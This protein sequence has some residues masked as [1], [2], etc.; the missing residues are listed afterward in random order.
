MNWQI[1]LFQAARGDIP[2]E[3]FL[4]ML[5]AGTQAKVI[6][7][8]DLLERYGP[9]LGMPHSK[10]IEHNLYE[11]RIRGT[12]EIRIFYCY[13]NKSIYLLHTFKKKTQKTPQREL[14]LARARMAQIVYD[15]TI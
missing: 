12:T 15:L 14:K 5:D 3:L 2:I 13:Q 8:I 1:E 10:R 6:H 9:R 11:L 7:L 4:R